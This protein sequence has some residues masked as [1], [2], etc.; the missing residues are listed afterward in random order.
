[1]L[2]EALAIAFPLAAAVAGVIASR[3]RFP[4]G[5]GIFVRSVKH[6]S[7]AAQMAADCK[8]M[9]LAW[10]TIAILWQKS[11][12]GT[13]FYH[14]DK[15]PDYAQQLRREGIKVWLWAWPEPGRAEQIVSTYRKV[16]SKVKVEGLILNPEQP[17]QG[18]SE[19]VAAR[20]VAVLQGL[21]VP[22]GLCTY[23][24]P[25]SWHPR[26]P[27]RA[28]AQC[29]FGMPELY[30]T[31]HKWDERHQA[32]TAKGWLRL[33]MRYLVPVWGASDGHTATQMQVEIAQTIAGFAD[34]GADFKAAAWWD[35]YWTERSQSRQ[36]VIREY[37]I[38]SGRIGGA[39]A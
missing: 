32:A 36:T 18:T 21:G 30:D 13:N 6:A 15:I 19:D 29:D 1:V 35:Y 22:L 25:P 7:S 37:E 4:R 31:S 20:D 9:G 26:F 39:V 17:Y 3:R 11:D 12:G 34:A 10:V 24:A 23:G 33:G 27:W 8:R 2:F 16:A 28:W 5:K 14:L 38:G